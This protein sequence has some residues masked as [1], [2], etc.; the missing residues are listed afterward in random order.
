[1]KGIGR[2]GFN[3][4]QKLLWP[5]AKPETGGPSVWLGEPQL[6][7][8]AENNTGPAWPGSLDHIWMPFSTGTEG[9][10][11]AVIYSASF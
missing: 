7:E 6:S 10:A 8:Y 1:M 2:R 5:R 4:N 9:W 11:T 3:S